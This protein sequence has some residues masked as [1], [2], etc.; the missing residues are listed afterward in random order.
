MATSS[1]ATTAKATTSKATT[2]KATT[3][4]AKATTAKKAPVKKVTTAKV[5]EEIVTPIIE[6]VFETPTEVIETVE[7]TN[8]IVETPIIEEVVETPTEVIEVSNEVIETS[9]DNE[10]TEPITIE[11]KFLIEAGL[12]WKVVT[13]TMQTTTSGV[14]VPKAVALFR[15][16]TK[17]FLS[18]RG[19]SYEVYQNEQL[20]ELLMK[21]SEQTGL[22]LHKGGFFGNGEK[23]FLQ[24]K[25][26]DFNLGNDR[27]EGYITGVNSFD[28][29]TSL[30]FGPSNITISCQNSFF[31][32]FRELKTKVRHTKNMVIRIEDILKQLDKSL[33]EEKRI[34][35][36]IKIMS[37]VQSTEL[38]KDMV[39][40]QLFDIKP[41]AILTDEEQVSTYKRNRIELLN[42][43]IAHQTNEKGNTLWGLFSG[44]T[45]YTTHVMGRDNI[46]EK[47][48]SEEKLFGHYGNRERQIFHQ[49][50][51]LVY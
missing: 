2:A 22:Q 35:E 5:V 36:T 12:N 19:E 34:F 39:I 38:H 6:Q 25:S 29:T 32:A 47:D 30:A 27:I 40:R 11:K 26:T 33:V 49:M 8:E 28:G 3:A 4:K 50:A 31:A 42:G 20:I 48:N 43:S 17:E 24:L 16:D 7:V 44:V 9:N 10:P 13:E 23:V 1:K 15:D 51:E 41:N 37:E 46:G 18:V 14:I 45:H 21:V